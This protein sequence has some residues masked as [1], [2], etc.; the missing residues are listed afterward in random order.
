MSMPQKQHSQQR[1]AKELRVDV[2]ERG[3]NDER[4]NNQRYRS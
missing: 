4:V 3:I 2:F 1:H